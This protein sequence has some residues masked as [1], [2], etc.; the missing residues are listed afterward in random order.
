MQSNLIK[1]QMQSNIVLALSTMLSQLS[2][3]PILN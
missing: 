1:L 3:T 2:E